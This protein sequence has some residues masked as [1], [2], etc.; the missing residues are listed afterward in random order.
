MICD[1]AS[2][3]V[4]GYGLDSGVQ[5]G[6]VINMA[7][8]QRVKQLIALGAK[9]GEG[10]RVD[11]RGTTVKGYEGGYFVKPASLSQVDPVNANTMKEV[12]GR[13]L[14]L[15]HVNTVVVAIQ[16]DYSGECDSKHR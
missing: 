11:G 15:L 5:M 12:F 16:L 9:E 4:V 3:R 10:V 14:I 13:V 1:A 6:P 2:S 7:S 8:K